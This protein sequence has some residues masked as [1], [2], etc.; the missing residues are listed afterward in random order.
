MLP[1]SKVTVEPLTHYNPHLL[2]LLC[3]HGL[4]DESPYKKYA[5]VYIKRHLN[6][7]SEDFRA[8][9][10]LECFYEEQL[11]STYQWLCKADSKIESHKSESSDLKKSWAAKQNLLFFSKSNTHFMVHSALPCYDL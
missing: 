2:G 11:Q 6:S 7:I 5:D 4:S 8:V 10:K 1:D 3:W 9:K